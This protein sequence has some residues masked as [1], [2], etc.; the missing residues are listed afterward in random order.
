MVIEFFRLHLW[1]ETVFTDDVGALQTFDLDFVSLVS[2]HFRSREKEFVITWCVRGNFHNRLNVT[3]N[4]AVCLI[5]LARPGE[6]KSIVM[7]WCRKVKKYYTT[8][9]KGREKNQFFFPLSYTSQSFE[10]WIVL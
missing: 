7:S 4:Y 3:S 9:E 5:I 1:L 6:K 10:W 2:N 8:L